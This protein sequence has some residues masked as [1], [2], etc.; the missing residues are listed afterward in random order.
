MKQVLKKTFSVHANRKE[1]I[2]ILF[3]IDS[4]LLVSEMTLKTVEEKLVGSFAIQ[5]AKIVS[6]F[7]SDVIVFS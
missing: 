1:K 2:I 7:R 4:V 5:K 6:L 3:Q